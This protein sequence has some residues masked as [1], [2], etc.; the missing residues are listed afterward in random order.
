VDGLHDVGRQRFQPV[1]GRGVGGHVDQN[2]IV[3]AAHPAGLATGNHI[4]TGKRLHDC[5]F[6]FNGFNGEP[7]NPTM[8]RTDN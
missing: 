5:S 3:R 4:T 7:D 1:N 6:F 8:P 2:F